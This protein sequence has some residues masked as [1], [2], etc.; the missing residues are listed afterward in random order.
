MSHV[1]SRPKQLAEMTGLK[2]HLDIS[3]H[4]LFSF[5]EPQVLGFDCQKEPWDPRMICHLVNLQHQIRTSFVGI[6]VFGSPLTCVV[7]IPFTN[8]RFLPPS[9]ESPVFKT[10]FSSSCS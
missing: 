6:T 1:A 8:L 7:T 2:N 5:S 4:S 3:C 9:L 10:F